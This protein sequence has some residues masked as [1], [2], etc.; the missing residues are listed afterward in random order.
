MDIEALEQIL[1]DSLAKE[2]VD[3]ENVPDGIKV[4]DVHFMKVGIDVDR[5]NKNR[6]KL[7]ELLAAY[8]TTAYGHPIHKLSESPSYTEV[9]AVVDD[10]K[11]ALILFALGEVLGFW[12]VKTPASLGIY[13]ENADKLAGM[14]LVVISGYNADSS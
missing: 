9:G 5:A 4:V 6:G 2:Q 13:G 10:Q 11:R 14:G 1:R 8:P 7:I 12:Q 3:V